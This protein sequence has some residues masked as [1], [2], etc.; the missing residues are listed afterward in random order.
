VLAG[1]HLCAQE[2]DIFDQIENELKKE[3][4]KNKAVDK[5]SK[6]AEKYA[7]KYKSTIAAGDAYFRDE[8]FEQALSAYKEALIYK[9]ED[10]YAPKKVKETEGAIERQK[11]ERAKEEKLRQYQAL[12][13]DGKTLSGQKKFKLAEA[14]FDEALQMIPGEAEAAQLKE[15]AKRDQA[16]FEE[17][18]RQKA[19]QARIDKEYDVAIKKAESLLSAKSF[20]PAREAFLEASKIKPQEQYPRD[21][22]DECAR[23]AKEEKD[24]NYDEKIAEADGLLKKEEFDAAIAAY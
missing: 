23:L 19:E 6:N 5:A 13:L 17:L 12:I 4:A 16:H 1:S 11:E 3:K 18:E 20:Q 24:R 10:D 15:Q 21:K 14:K 22:M 2:D 7:L 9:R 8:K